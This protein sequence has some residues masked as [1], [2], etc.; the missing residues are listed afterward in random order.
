[1]LAETDPP[2]P[3]PA[4]GEAGLLP[5]TR[6]GAVGPND[7]AATDGTAS[8][9]YA[10][11]SNPFGGRSPNGDDARVFGLRPK[12]TMQ[13][14]APDAEPATIGKRRFH[15][16][17]RLQKAYASKRHPECPVDVDSQLTQGGDTLRH[18]TF[19]AG[20]LNRRP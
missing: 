1:M 19:A 13:V 12:K 10:R 9:F 6:V 14:D 15:G 20:F 2:Q 5:E 4:R 18:Q 17:S 3:R 7:P 11:S 16:E 8:D